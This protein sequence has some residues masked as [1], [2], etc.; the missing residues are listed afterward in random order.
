MWICRSGGPRRLWRSSSTS[1]NSSKGPLNS[2]HRTFSISSVSMG[3]FSPTRLNL[4]TSARFSPR[5]GLVGTAYTEPGPSSLLALRPEPLRLVPVLGLQV[6]GVRETRGR[7]D[8]GL[9]R[10]R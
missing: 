1:A 7:S 5:T 9:R 8:T 4:T 6:L 3:T 2:Q 10:L